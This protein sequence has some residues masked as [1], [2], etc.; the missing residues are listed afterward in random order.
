MILSR[1][2]I[3]ERI[4]TGEVSFTPGLDGFQMQPHAVD[5]RLGL[6][7]HI[8]KTWEL[9]K[10]GRRAIMIDPLS[11]TAAENFDTVTLK[12]GQ[13][14]ELLPQESVIGTTYEAIGL[15]AKDL[16]CVLYPRS[17]INRRGLSVALSG[18]IDVGY[19]GHLMIPIVN[20]TDQQLI[21]IYPG[22]RVCQV[23]FQKISSDISAED[24]QLHG[25]TRAKY[26]GGKDGFIGGKSDREDE[27]QL[28]REGRLA[29]LKKDFALPL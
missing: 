20:N 5:L 25:L 15:H 18:I 12:P 9:T 4:R 23:V 10:E 28:I 17:S 11:G 22:E 29:A 2:D 7:F 16:M 27:M 19:T 8:P 14:F 24:A 13:Y 3:Q 1:A 26:N 21:R 6:E